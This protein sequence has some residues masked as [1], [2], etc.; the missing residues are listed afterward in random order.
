M[1]RSKTGVVRR[2][3]H[4]KILKQTKGYYLTRSKLYRRAHEAY[5]KAGEYSYIGRKLRKRDIK[6]LWIMRINA[7]TRERGYNYSRF[8]KLLK[9]SNINLNRKSLSELAVMSP[10]AF[11]AVLDEALSQQDK[12]AKS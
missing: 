11:N 7:A 9:N 10:E 3:K 5:L 2:R 6:K 4:K 12:P 8:M 1:P